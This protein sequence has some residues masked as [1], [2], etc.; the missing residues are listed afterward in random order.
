VLVGDV[1]QL[2]SVGAGAA[3]AQLQGAGMETAH[4]TEIVRQTNA[5]TK[6]AVEATLEG[7]IRRA[8]DALDAGAVSSLKRRRPKRAAP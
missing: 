6:E 8:F 7:Q 4:L 2:G 3:F 5:K 1:K